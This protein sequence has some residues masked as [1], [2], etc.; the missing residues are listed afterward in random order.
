MF[1]YRV[2]LK[3]LNVQGE[4]DK[5]SINILQDTF[6]FAASLCRPLNVCIS[7]RRMIDGS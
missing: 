5:L 1:A 3:L 6:Q 2:F 4:C 7:L